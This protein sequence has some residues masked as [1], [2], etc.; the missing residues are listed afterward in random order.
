MKN[1]YIPFGYQ[2]KDGEISTH[3]AEAEIVKEIFSRYAA[4]ETLKSIAEALTAQ[5]IKY[6]PDK[7]TWDKARVKRV[8]DNT[9][10]LGEKGHPSVISADLFES[11]QQKKDKF[12]TKP[13]EIDSTIKLLKTFAVCAECGHFLSRRV[14]K[15]QKTPIAW[16]CPCCGLSIRFSDED[17]KARVLAILNRLISTPSLVEVEKSG[18]PIDSL[19]ARRSEQELHRMM[20]AGTFSEDDYLNMVLR[21]AAKTYESITSARHI[22][23]RLTATL[24]HAEPLSSFDEKLFVQTVENILI[25]R[26]GGISLKFQNGKRILEEGDYSD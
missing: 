2:I 15:R 20:D 7:Y 26:S 14:D 3:P 12:R 11:V 6:L 17:L 21:C 18:T 19:E 23:D 1:R 10:Y 5:R 9:I 8:L 13:V 4:G 25:D 16:K 22:S 24:Y